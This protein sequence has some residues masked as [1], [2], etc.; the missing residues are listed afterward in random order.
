MKKLLIGLFFIGSISAYAGDCKVAVEHSQLIP[1]ELHKILVNK[2]YKIV[3]LQR[4][5][6][7]HIEG[8]CQKEWFDLDFNKVSP[9]ARIFSFYAA[10]SPLFP[11]IA[12]H[13][14]ITR[15]YLFFNAPEINYKDI[16]NGDHF[17]YPNIFLNQFE[18]KIPNCE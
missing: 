15:T 2:G 18:K 3:T 4:I 8:H 10:T 7:C 5:E 16:K 6:I 13:P 9:P 1:E 17:H 14:E 11:R 12:L